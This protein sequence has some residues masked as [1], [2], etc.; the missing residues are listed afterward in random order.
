MLE[1]LFTEDEAPAT[2][3]TDTENCMEDEL[4][5][6]LVCLMRQRKLHDILMWW[7]AKST[8]QLMARQ[9]LAVPATSAGVE[10]L[11]SKASLTHGDLAQAIALLSSMHKH[12]ET[13][14]GCV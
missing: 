3:R 13:E 7:K 10:C 1:C 2:D 9:Y 8:W 5:A 14:S 11:F 6:Y 12:H 4:E